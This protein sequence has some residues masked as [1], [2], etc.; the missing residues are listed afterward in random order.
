MQIDKTKIWLAYGRSRAFFTLC[1]RPFA[2][3]LEGTGDGGA[4]AHRGAP[5]HGGAPAHRGAPAHS[6]CTP[7]TSPCS[8]AEARAWWNAVL[9]AFH[10]LAGRSVPGGT[11]ERRVPGGT[12][13]NAVLPPCSRASA[14][15]TAPSGHRKA[16]EAPWSHQARASGISQS[17][18]RLLACALACS[19][20]VC[21]P[22]SSSWT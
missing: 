14:T 5:A 8:R 13:L 22:C 3:R 20:P 11:V 10:S 17:P 6:S 2:A 9:P 1:R 18:R 15:P 7:C 16:T 12:A 21:W 4:P 19:S